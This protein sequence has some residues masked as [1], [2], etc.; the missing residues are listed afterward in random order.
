MMPADPPLHRLVAREGRLLLGADR[1]DV[2]GL[3]QRRQPDLELAGA[4]E[5]L[6]DEEPRAALAFLLDDLVERGDPVVG[7]VRVDVG[8]LVLELVEIHVVRPVGRAPESRRR[9]VSRVWGSSIDWS[10]ARQREYLRASAALTRSIESASAAASRVAGR[11]CPSTWMATAGLAMASRYQ[12]APLAV[13]GSDED[14]A[15]IDDDPDDR[16]MGGAVRGRG[17]DLDLLGCVEQRQVGGFEA[18]S[19]SVAHLGRIR[20]SWPGRGP[21]REPWSCDATPLQYI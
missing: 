14:V 6:V 12:R 4:L 2:A 21:A 11:R 20:L 7:L 5:Q 9:V 19:G 8:Q 1:V 3:G 10:E 18:H 13:D 15:G 17:L 16:A